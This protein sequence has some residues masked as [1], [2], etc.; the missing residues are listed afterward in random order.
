MKYSHIK[1]IS[2]MLLLIH[3][4][5]SQLIHELFFPV[6]INISKMTMKSVYLKSHFLRMY[7]SYKR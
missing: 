5:N 2:C 7:L 1:V 6:T 4:R 3:L